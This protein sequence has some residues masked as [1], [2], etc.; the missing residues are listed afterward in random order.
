LEVD[1]EQIQGQKKGKAKGKGKAKAKAKGKEKDIAVR[2]FAFFLCI[3]LNDS[4]LAT[5]DLVAANCSCGRDEAVGFSKLAGRRQTTLWVLASSVARA[6]GSEIRL[7]SH[8][9]P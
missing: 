7:W 9:W 1:E 2:I 6:V 4:S 5:V 3:Q 8:T